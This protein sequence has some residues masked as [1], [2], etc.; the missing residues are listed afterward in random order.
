MRRREVGWEVVF[1]SGREA[2]T[3]LIGRL[4]TEAAWAI[5]TLAGAFLMFASL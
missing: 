1:H 5:W 2:E 4:P 3:A